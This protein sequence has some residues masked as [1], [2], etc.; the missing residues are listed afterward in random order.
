MNPTDALP[1]LDWLVVAA[2]VAGVVGFGVSF[3]RRAGGNLEAFFISGR[4]LPWY[5]A[6]ISLVA[7]GFSSDTPLW[8]SSLVRRHG[9]PAAWQYWAPAIGSVLAAVYFGRLWRRMGFV[10]DI[11]LLETRYGGT[12]AGV[13]RGWAGFSG[14]LI[15]C[16]LI[17]S[18]V[19]KGMETILREAMGLPEEYRAVTTMV[20]VVA[21]LVVGV[22][23]GL[24]GIVYSEFVQFFIAIGG[25]IAL[26]FFSVRAVG[27]LDE[28]VAA[29]EPAGAGMA[30][31]ELGVVPALGSGPGHMPVGTAIGLFGVLWMLTA[32]S[33]GHGAQKLLAT[34]DPRHA[35][36][37]QLLHA[38]IYF[39]L[40]AW[41]W[42][43][44]ALCS[45]V[46]MPELGTA[47]AAVAYPRM[48]VQVLPA[49]L[50]GLVLAGMLCAFLSTASTLFNWGAS[51]LV[52]DFYRRFL[53]PGA[54]AR[55]YVLV[56]RLATVLIA[57][58][59]ALISFLAWDIQQLLTTF[60]VL[61]AGDA[62][63]RMMRWL[64]WRLTVQGDL[65]GMLTGWVLAFLVLF[66]R[67]LDVPAREF[68]G[69]AEEVRLSSDPALF[70]ARMVIVLTG[71]TLAAVTVSL[72]TRPTE[73]GRLAEFYRR[74]RPLSFGWRVV[75]KGLGEAGRPGEALGRT[76]LS[77][78]LGVGAVLGLIV[79]LG[80]VLLGSR[81][82]GG[83]ALVLAAMG[84]VVLVRRIEADF[85]GVL[86]EPRGEPVRDARSGGKAREKSGLT[87]RSS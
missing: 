49:G 54:E 61:A 32:A 62:V 73:A 65:A 79:G 16:P 80:Q 50:R 21:A 36:Y 43:L 37:A 41:P 27:G 52:N 18:W 69:W 35:T 39:G 55:V 26:A 22:A 57:L 6:G 25:S 8:V 45:L 68:F 53:H 46:L 44:V 64:W 48:I 31:L 72:L 84:I 83:G 70:G 28:L 17:V 87:A 29:L 30:P 77:W 51:Y 38:C 34:K 12:T 7:T 75:R 19:I 67:V 76:L 33:G 23:S 66:G 4:S 85:V 20:V 42:I 10:T 58:G 1:F 47:D 78:G 63:L 9:V 14:A 86:G 24:T 5:V 82:L 15:V 3:R 13:L 71:V 59:G 11:E 81:L 60:Y 74:A 56:G 2:V 40:L